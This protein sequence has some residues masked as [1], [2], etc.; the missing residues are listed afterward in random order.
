M[1]K[2]V[3]KYIHNPIG[4]PVYAYDTHAGVYDHCLCLSCNKFHPGSIDN[5]EIANLLYKICVMHEL[6]T[7]V[8]ECPEWEEKLVVI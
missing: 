4:R 8:Y 2:K 1:N 3:I 5:C 7:P 6:V